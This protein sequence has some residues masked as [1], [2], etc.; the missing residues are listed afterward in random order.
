MPK[1]L[2][3]VCRMRIATNVLHLIMLRFVSLSICKLNGLGKILLRLIISKISN[4][5]AIIINYDLARCLFYDE[6]RLNI[7]LA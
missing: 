1:V 6:N 2:L 5:E 4:Y 3:P 7:F